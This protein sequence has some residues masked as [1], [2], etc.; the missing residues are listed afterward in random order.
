MLAEIDMQATGTI[1]A[2][3][4]KEVVTVKASKR[5]LKFTTIACKKKSRFVV[6][7]QRQQHPLL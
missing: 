7:S 3:C 4:G 1:G 6:D 2:S 5:I